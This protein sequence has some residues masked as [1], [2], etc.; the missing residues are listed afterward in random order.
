MSGDILCY[1][2]HGVSG[3]VV[4]DHEDIYHFGL[5]LQF[6]FCGHPLTLILVKS[7]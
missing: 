1:E 2:G 4:G 7:R 5:L 6:L 3:K